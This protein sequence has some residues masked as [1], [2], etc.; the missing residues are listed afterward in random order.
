M[1][2][3]ARLIAAIFMAMAGVIVIIVAV[4]EFPDAAYD[5]F[6]MVVTAAIVGFLVG[7]R[8]L[9]RAIAVEDVR[10]ASLGLRAGVTA[11]FWTL[12][13]FG[14]WRMIQ[15]IMKHEFYQPLSAIL[16]MLWEMIRIGKLALTNLPLVITMVVLSWIAG[17]VTKNAMLKW[18][19]SEDFLIHK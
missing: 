13:M 4:N 17:V 7:W 5:Q 18:D 15:G 10:A 8:G 9:G 6:P 19:R 14:L 2:T 16:T 11:F 12:F 1:P 3:A